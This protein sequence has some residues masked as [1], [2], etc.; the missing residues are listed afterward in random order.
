M[1]VLLV[2][3]VLIIKFV[4]AN[5][6]LVVGSAKERYEIALEIIAEA[7]DVFP[8]IFADCLDCSYVLF[9][10][11]VTFEAVSVSTLFLACLTV[12]L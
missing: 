4:R 3:D 10:L 6:L 8:W 5:K 11:D 7:L 12:P 2:P 1:D 9:T